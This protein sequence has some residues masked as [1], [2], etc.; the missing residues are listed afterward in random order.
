MARYLRWPS[1]RQAD[2]QAYVTAAN[3]YSQTN[4]SE[5]FAAEWYPRADVEGLWVSPYF[6]P[7]AVSPFGEIVEPE[8]MVPLRADAELAEA[9]EIFWPDEE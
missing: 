8:E 4:F 5:Q 7:P 2:A 6:G 9:S 3:A 1:D